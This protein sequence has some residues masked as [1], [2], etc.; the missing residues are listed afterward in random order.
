MTLPV[1]VIVVSY[2]TRE[3]LLR[4]LAALRSACQGEPYEV[5]VVDNGSTDGSADAVAEL[6]PDARLLRL[7]HNVGFA[8]AV[9]A[10]AE[11]ARG[12]W[13][14]LLNPDTEPVGDVIGKFVAF[15]RANPEHR[16][17]TG[18]TL[19]PEG[20]DDGHS[21]FGLPSVWGYV[22]F[23]TGLTTLFRR[24]RWCNP[25]ELPGLDRSTPSRVPAASGCLLLVE[26]ALFTELGGLAPDYF[27][28]CEDI[29]FCLR[30]ARH[31]ADPV[32]VPQARV[33]HLGGAA[34]TGVGKRVMLLQGKVTYLRLRWSRPRAALGRALLAVGV[35]VRAAGS[36]LTGRADHW[37]RVWA[38]RR[39]WRAGWPPVAELPPVELVGSPS[40]GAAPPARVPSDLGVERPR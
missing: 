37:P 21:A 24:S 2:Q 14:L 16:V 26:R 12:R 7:R 40:D 1:S 36:R 3:L 28:Y 4:A 13:L 22:C 11:R 5:I 9:N 38:Q 35:A 27:M 10:G 17:Y 30:A 20:G 6:F 31:G 8:R 18:R 25:E 29:D 23:A 15:A 39:T 32:L 19:R 34:S 33:V